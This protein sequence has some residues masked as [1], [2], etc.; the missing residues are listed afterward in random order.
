M[1]HSSHLSQLFG[2]VNGPIFIKI[3]E[4][5]ENPSDPN[6]VLAQNFYIEKWSESGYTI[7]ITLQYRHYVKRLHILMVLRLLNQFLLRN[8]LVPR[9]FFSFLFLDLLKFLFFQ[10]SKSINQFFR[11]AQN[12]E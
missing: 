4:I 3:R 5:L 1:S 10:K 9:G 6:S 12:N 8:W 11:K 2:S 7:K